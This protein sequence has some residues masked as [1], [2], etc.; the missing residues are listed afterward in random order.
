MGYKYNEEEFIKKFPYPKKS[1]SFLCA[2]VKAS[3]C[4]LLE[5][6]DIKKTLQHRV[7]S[8]VAVEVHG[9]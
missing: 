6:I 3:C 9:F 5:W 2:V 1:V 7:T 8:S 4:F